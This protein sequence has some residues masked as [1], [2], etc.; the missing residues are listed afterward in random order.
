MRHSFTRAYTI[1]KKDNKIARATILNRMKDDLISLYEEY[2]IVKKIMDILED[3][4]SPNFKLI[5]NY[6]LR[7]TTAHMSENDTTV[8]HITKIEIMARD[9]SNVGHPVS[10]EMQVFILLNSLPKS[11]ESSNCFH[12]ITIVYYDHITHDAS[13]RGSWNVSEE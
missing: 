11:W 8:D 12:K 3:K 4:Y 9:L 10:D 6:I 1:W 13:Y 5:F 7:S 2:M